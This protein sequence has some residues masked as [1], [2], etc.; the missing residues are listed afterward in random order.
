M[1]IGVQLIQIRARQWM[2]CLICVRVLNNEGSHQHTK[3]LTFHALAQTRPITQADAVLRQF[4]P[5]EPQR[6]EIHGESGFGWEK[7]RALWGS[8]VV[9][10]S[11]MV[12]LY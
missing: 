1:S 3:Q 10:A 9:D 4:Q 7:S 2:F 12:R 5:S 11:K 6:A 8:Q